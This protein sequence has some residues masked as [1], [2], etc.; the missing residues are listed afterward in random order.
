MARR[1]DRMSETSVGTNA[2]TRHRT[3]LH[4]G[5]TR[6]YPPERM[7][8]GYNDIEPLGRQAKIGVKPRRYRGSNRVV[9]ITGRSQM[10]GLR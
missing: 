1:N 10:E 7:G 3:R 5:P 9:A 2:G 6:G 8:K 4:Y